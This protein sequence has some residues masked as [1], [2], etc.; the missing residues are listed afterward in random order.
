MNAEQETTTYPEF[1]TQ[2]QEKSSIGESAHEESID[3]VRSAPFLLIHLACLAIF[4]V[5]ISPVAVITCLALYALRMFGITAGYH[6]YFSHRSF[7]T[8][9][10]FQFVLGWL[11]ATATQKG[12]LWWAAHHRH[13]H[14]TS[15]TEED[16]HSPRHG[17]WWS[18]VGWFL[19]NKF[20]A[21]NYR[22]I[23]DLARFRELRFLNRCY[24]LPPMT[25]ALGVSALGWAL[26]RWFPTLQTSP[27]QMLV[28]GYFLS[29]VLLYHGTFTVN[30]LAH[31]IGRQRFATKDDSRNSL[32]IAMLTLGEGWHN[33]HHFV[34]SSERQGFYWWEVDVTHYALKALSWLGVVWDL[35]KPPRHIYALAS[36]QANRSN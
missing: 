4:W 11:G 9:R 23:P 15:D 24:V 6:R 5:G 26:D 22:L 36:G 35:K 13:H 21:T 32:L 10:V 2:T 19:C 12:P 30:S 16:A 17:F 1:S 28:W 7:K 29:T 34:P 33:N 14:A 27:L 31:V 8:S 18:H 20:H 3:W 25:L